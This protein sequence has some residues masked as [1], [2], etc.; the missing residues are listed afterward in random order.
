MAEIKLRVELPEKIIDERTLQ[1]ADDLALI[2]LIHRRV[3]E[4]SAYEIVAG[5]NRTVSVPVALGWGLPARYG[6]DYEFG[7]ERLAITPKI[8][9]SGRLPMNIRELVIKFM[10]EDTRG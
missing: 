2:E 3:K 10:S 8:F 6:F 9:F 1:I 4:K 5:M 7:D